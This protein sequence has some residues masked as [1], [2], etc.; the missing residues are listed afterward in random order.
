MVQLSQHGSSTAPEVLSQPAASERSPERDGA[1]GPVTAASRGDTAGRAPGS[2]RD[3]AEPQKQAAQGGIALKKWFKKGCG[4]SARRWGEAAAGPGD[5]EDRAGARLHPAASGSKH[6]PT[7][8][9][10]GSRDPTG[11]PLLSLSFLLPTAPGFDSSLQGNT[12]AKAAGKDWGRARA[13]QG[14]ALDP[15]ST[16]RSRAG[17]GTAPGRSKL[18]SRS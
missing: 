3:G 7:H 14:G 16:G 17:L 6:S 4:V 5:S 15:P 12:N 13:S 10:C 9:K 8:P 18:W 1:H 11:T 2:C